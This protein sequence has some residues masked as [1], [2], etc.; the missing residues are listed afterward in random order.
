MDLRTYDEGTSP[1][2]SP[3]NAGNPPELDVNYEDWK[4]GWG[5]A[6]GIANTHELT[7]WPFAAMPSDADTLAMAQTNAATPALICTP[8]Y[9]NK[10]QV[11]GYWTLPDRTEPVKKWVEDNR[12]WLH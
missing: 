1:T 9:Y 4:L 7:L 6:Y 10:Q 11:F 5:T 12:G 2:P 3:A 8:E